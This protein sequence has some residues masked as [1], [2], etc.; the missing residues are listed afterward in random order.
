MENKA[1]KGKTGTRLGIETTE[2]RGKNRQSEKRKTGM[3]DRNR[4]GM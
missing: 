4:K 3:D 2:G 1:G